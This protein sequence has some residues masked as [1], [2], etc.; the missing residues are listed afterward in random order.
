M[1]GRT[2]DL[3]IMLGDPRKAVKYMTLPLIVSFL[4]AQINVFADT[5][6]C[7][8]LGSTASS[9]VSSIFPIY[10]IIA[11]LG[12][13]LGVG[14]SASIS[15]HLGRD[16]KEKADSLALQTLFLSVLFS[17]AITP[18]LY[19]MLDPI[20]HWMGAGDIAP[21][22]RAYM[23]P[24]ILLS[25][26]IIMIGSVSG[27]LRSEGAAKKSM[28]ILLLSAVL[29]MVLD[30]VLMYGLGMGLAGAG[31]ATVFATGVAVILGFYWYYAKDTYLDITLKG[32]RVKRDEM[33]EILYVGIPRV[34]ESLIVNA[35]SLVQRYFVIICG[36]TLAVAF[37]NIPWRFVA[38][39]DVLPMAVGAALVP[40]CSA[41]LGQNNFAKAEVG[42]RYSFKI[43]MIFMVVVSVILFVFAEYCVLP[44]TYSPSMAE[45]RPQFVHILR[46]YVIMIP[47]VGMIDIGSAILQSLRMAQ[48]SM[49]SSLLRNLM[50]VILFVLASTISMD[51]I[52][53]S[54]IVTEIAGGLLMMGLAHW[55]FKRYRNMNSKVSCA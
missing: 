15:R 48:L 47:F 9:A 13:G 21:L 19:I 55:A 7:S 27:L 33:W 52:Y 51:A 4:V 50:L 41:A 6:W 42:Y 17:V 2:K 40:V 16:N 24:Q 45:L 25:I 23:E 54:L 43:S 30:P 10:W 31:W 20:A 1:T 18:I 5:A 22:C 49:V 35:M 32:F 14:A 37:Y 53:W 11:G 3:D 26:S 39:A 8:G 36:G 38:L 46:L 29:N 28:T 12:T 34:T 44:F